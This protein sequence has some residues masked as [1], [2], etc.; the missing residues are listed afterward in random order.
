MAKKNIRAQ[1][2][3]SLLRHVLDPTG[4]RTVI[5]DAP[6]SDYIRGS[7]PRFYRPLNESHEFSGYGLALERRDLMDA[8]TV[9]DIG[10]AI[11][12]WFRENGWQVNV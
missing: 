7:V 12:V 11:I 6:A 5:W 10:G 3:M 1:T 2:I 4:R 8:K 9:A